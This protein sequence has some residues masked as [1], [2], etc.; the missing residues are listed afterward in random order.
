VYIERAHAR[1]ETIATEHR[2]REAIFR[3]RYHA[4]LREGAI[5]PNASERFADVLDDPSNP[6]QPLEFGSY[7]DGELASSIR[8]HVASRQS[9]DPALNGFCDLLSPE[10]ATGKTIIRRAL[11]RTGPPRSGFSSYAT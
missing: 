4:Y 1:E 11:S 9:S 5:A 7:V 3:Q 6:W 2:E 10:L 8:L